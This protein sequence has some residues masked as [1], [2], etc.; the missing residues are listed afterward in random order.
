[1][2][3]C[4]TIRI[5]SMQ[6]LWRCAPIKIQNREENDFSVRLFSFW[7]RTKKKFMQNL[8][9]CVL[10]YIRLV[11]YANLELMQLRCKNNTQYHWLNTIEHTIMLS[12]STVDV[13][14]NMKIRK[15][16]GIFAYVFVCFNMQYPNQQYKYKLMKKC[17]ER[18][19]TETHTYEYS[20]TR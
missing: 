17:K 1:M 19:Q 18:I 4:Y 6:I 8:K 7:V 16:V 3:Y 15:S 14:R 9:W 11:F 2:C 5:G 12:E 13:D 20:E 10:M